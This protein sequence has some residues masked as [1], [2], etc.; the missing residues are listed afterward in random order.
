MNDIVRS[1]DFAF[2]V[3]PDWA[4]LPE[5]WSLKEVV[6]MAIDPGDR[7]FLFCRGEHPLIVFDRDGNFLS[8]WGEGLF[9]RPHGITIGP[10]GSLYCT[11]DK[12]HVIRKFTPGGELLFTLGTPGKSAPFQSGE[13]FNQPTKI[14][15]E[16]GTG[17]FY[18]ADGYGN[19]RVHKYS[20]DGERLF[21]WGASGSAPGEFNLV[22]SVATDRQG[23]VYV[24]DRE[25]HRV[26]V[27]DD[28]G[29]YITQWNN[30]HR[31]CGLCIT[32]GDPQRA[33]IGQIPPSLRVNE[34]Y[35]N[36]GACLSIHDLN[37]KKLASFG[38]PFPGEDLPDQFW[39]PHGVAAD[40]RGDIYV[41]E[42]SY[43]HF[44]LASSPPPWTRRCLRK[45]IRVT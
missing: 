25:N 26:Q 6:D 20:A 41:G 45:M 4:K 15:L 37:G 36:L 16:P 29:R 3:D 40:S 27:F 38:Q 24:A 32:P 31:P 39:A 13:P 11:D 43:S 33:L 1:G 23:R 28:T 19:A 44:G 10:D 12:D 34:K 17:N 22:H 2:R 5:G 9:N 42:V 14:A 18:V 7:V 35:P 8:S 21:S 30:L